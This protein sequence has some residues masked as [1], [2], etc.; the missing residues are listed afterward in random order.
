MKT[1]ICLLIMAAAIMLL[2]PSCKTPP[3]I[4]NTP[5]IIENLNVTAKHRY[6]VEYLGGYK[7]LQE[8]SCEI[9]CT[10]SDPEGDKLTYRWSADGGSISGGG[11][12]ITWTAPLGAGKVTLNVTVSNSG[13]G[14]ATKSITFKVETCAPCAFG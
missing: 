6:L 9:N 1:R 12:I 13:G 8:K 10:A 4:L 11:P 3:P 2:V 14:A 5:P 7:I